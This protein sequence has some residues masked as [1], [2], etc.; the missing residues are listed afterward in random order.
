M[1][2]V[3]DWV[4]IAKDLPVRHSTRYVHECSITTDAIITNRG[5]GYTLYCFKCGHTDYRSN[6]IR[7]LTELADIRKLNELAQE[8][9]NIELPDDTTSNIPL[10]YKSWLYKASLSNHTIMEAG[11]GWSPSLHRIVLPLYGSDNNLQYWQGRAVIPNQVPKYINPPYDKTRLIY[12]ATNGNR[13]RVIVTEDILSAIR[14]G[15]HLPAVSIM[16]TAT[17]YY[18]ANYLSQ[19]A[20][21][22]YWLDP[23]KA[24][25]RGTRKG[26]QMLSTLTCVDAL[27]SERDPKN[28][29][30]REIREV[31]G[32]TKQHRYIYHGAV[33][34]KDY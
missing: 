4:Q 22:S 19:Y 33:T 28:L 11:I 3:P 7:T 26:V 20:R 18:Q 12:T 23:D 31:L 10:E 34:F 15:N 1:I 2:T 14:V 30:N 25:R 13:D 5:N 21:V 24:G 32:L 9:Q 29:S 6:G 17:S 27:T 8:T 16:G